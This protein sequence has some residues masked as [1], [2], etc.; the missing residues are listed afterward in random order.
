MLTKA[1]FSNSCDFILCKF[2]FLF[3]FFCFCSVFFGYLEKLA[4][5]F[6]TE[7]V[8]SFFVIRRRLNCKLSSAL[9]FSQNH[10]VM[11]KYSFSV[12]ECRAF[13][14]L[15]PGMFGLHLFKRSNAGSLSQRI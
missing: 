1:I 9:P 15:A 4:K 7:D 14:L 8:A 13:Y 6:F 11:C 5:V 12:R 10:V 3:A 2:W